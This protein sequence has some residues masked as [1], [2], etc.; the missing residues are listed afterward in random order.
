MTNEGVSWG[1]GWAP[2][3]SRLSYSSSSFAP[4]RQVEAFLA[5]HPCM[6]LLRLQITGTSLGK[7]LSMPSLSLTH[8][9]CVPNAHWSS[10]TEGSWPLCSKTGGVAWVLATVTSRLLLCCIITNRSDVPVWKMEQ[11]EPLSLPG[12]YHT[13]ADKL[14]E[15]PIITCLSKKFLSVLWNWFSKSLD[16][17]WRD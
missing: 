7:G 12:H 8:H 10:A 2:T 16:L 6:S 17:S 9:D 15:K 11:Q 3:V 4:W 5:A 1:E 13:L 14:M